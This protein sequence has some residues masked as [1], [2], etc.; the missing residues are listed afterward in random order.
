MSQISTQPLPVPII[1]NP[2]N[3]AFQVKKINLNEVQKP[4][5]FE[6]LK[7]KFSSIEDTEDAIDLKMAP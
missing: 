1:K 4:D 7:T 3:F 2:H 6:L 5:Y